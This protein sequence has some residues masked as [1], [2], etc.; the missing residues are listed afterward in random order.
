MKEQRWVR[1]TPRSTAP[2]LANCLACGKPNKRQ[3]PGT[4][5][6]SREC[7]GNTKHLYSAKPEWWAWYKMKMR[8]TNPNVKD[9][10]LYG[11]RGITVCDRWMSF[12]SFLEDM[13]DKPSPE[14]SLDR[15]DNYGNYE[16]GNCRWATKKE[17]SN[18][19]RPRSEWNIPK[20]SGPHI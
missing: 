20:R 14:H 3:T 13:G 18:N 7:A 5:Y 8:C 1:R 19:R 9:Y 12:N 6:C 2:A 10:P 17:Q 11:G 4:K 16:P 15:I